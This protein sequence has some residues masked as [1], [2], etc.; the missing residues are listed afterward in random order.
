MDEN[1]INLEDLVKYEDGAYKGKVNWETSRGKIINGMYKGIKFEFEIINYI[2]EKQ[3]VEVKYLDKKYIVYTSSLLGL[4]LNYILGITMK[5]YRFNC[6]DFINGLEIL[7]TTRKEN[8]L[9]G[10]KTTIKAY[11][12]KCVKCGYEDI[13]SESNLQSGDSCKCCKNKVAIL[14]KNTIWDTDKFM[15]P[16]VGEEIAKTHVHGSSKYVDVTCPN[17]GMKSNKKRQI[18]HIYQDKGISCI[19]KDSITYPEKFIFKLLNIIGIDFIYQLTSKKAKWVKNKRYDFY[20]SMNGEEFIIEAN[21]EQHPNTKYYNE[22]SFEKSKINQQKNDEYKKELA[23]GNRIKEE[24][25]IVIDCSLSDREFIKGEILE[26]RLSRI[27]DLRNVNWNE[28]EE[29][30]VTSL[31]KMVCDYWN[32][33]NE[34][35][36]TSNLAEVFKLDRSTIR[37]YLKR[38]SGIGLCSYDAESEKKRG[39]DK[40]HINARRKVSVYD[41]YNNYIDTFESITHLVKVSLDKFGVKFDGGAITHTCKGEQKTHKGFTFKY[42]D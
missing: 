4:N 29:F 34:Y 28:C 12:V 11:T 9:K 32:I 6:G 2:K 19:C 35:E 15:I 18:N 7:G 21:G 17:C 5:E 1:F 27:F 42:V 36:T 16:I 23:L 3:V 25:Y 22:R 40:S 33:K 41:N 39:N 31:L 38:G 30:A 24:N 37:D 14:G 26:S 8:N 10:K 20:F 13:I